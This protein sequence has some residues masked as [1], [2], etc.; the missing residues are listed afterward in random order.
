MSNIRLIRGHIVYDYNEDV[1]TD[2]D[3]QS[4]TDDII[5]RFQNYIKNSPTNRSTIDLIKFLTELSF[6]LENIDSNENSNEFL[7]EQLSTIL[8]ILSKI[9]NKFNISLQDLIEFKLNK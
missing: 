3:F 6:D 9:S 7:K 4:T 8:I 1:D 5:E 2:S